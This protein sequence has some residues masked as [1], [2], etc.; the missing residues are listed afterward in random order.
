MSEYILGGL[1]FAGI[2]IV[3]AII[4]SI[5]DKAGHS[6]SAIKDRGY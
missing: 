2:F 5:V 3:P 4:V 6:N 1:I